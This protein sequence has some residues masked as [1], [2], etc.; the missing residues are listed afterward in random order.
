MLTTKTVC[1]PGAFIEVVPA[2]LLATLRYNQNGLLEEIR[3]GYVEQSSHI[4]EPDELKI[5]SN[6][7]PVSIP[8]IGGTTWVKGVFYSRTSLDA[9]GYIPKCLY[10]SVLESNDVAFYAGHVKSLAASFNGSMSVRNWLGL[11]KFRILPGMVVPTNFNEDSLKLLLTSANDIFAYPFI[12]GYMIYEGSEMRYEPE[13]LVHAKVKSVYKYLTSEGYLM[14]DVKTDVVSFNTS[15]SEVVKN[16][17]QTDTMIVFSPNSSACLHAYKSGSK[18]RAR[19]SDEVTCPICKKKY[20]VPLSGLVCC[21]DPTCVSKI[22]PTIQHML[23]VF[24][25]P[26]MSEKR[27]EDV[28]SNR[29]ILCLTD[30]LN[31]PEYKDI[32]L[33]GTMS[34][35]LNAVTPPEICNDESFFIKLADGCNNSVQTLMYYV[36][37]PLRIRTDFDFVTVQGQRFVQWLEQP[38]VALTIQTIMA[39]VNLTERTK[40]FEGAPIFRNVKIAITGSFRRGARETIRSIIESYSGEAVLSANDAAPNILVI[41]DLDSEI[42][43]SMIHKAKT[44]RIPIYRESEFFEQYGIDSDLASANL[45]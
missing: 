12:S 2:G 25:L 41:G 16:D 37:N 32:K 27:F 9:T 43:G 42:D 22:Y 24:N 15:Y 10:D 33:S 29:E 17:I 21:D 18:V 3:F 1:R 36:E 34:L 45:L 40:R 4:A 8:L 28:S 30:V 19:V 14:A 6:F 39:A 5:L 13:L 11:A 23:R 26:E 44:L 35:A 31:L 20:K 38:S 7:V